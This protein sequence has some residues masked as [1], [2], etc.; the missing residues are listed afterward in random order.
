MMTSTRL[1][2]ISALAACALMLGAG[3]ALANA[4]NGAVTNS[5]CQSVEPSVDPTCT[6]PSQSADPSESPHPSETVDPSTADATSTD[7]PVAAD[8]YAAAGVDPAAPPADP[9]VPLTGLDNAIQHVLDNCI[10]NPQAPGLANALAHLVANR[11]LHAA[12]NAEK[13]AA[14]ASREVAKAARIAEHDTVHGTV[15][16]NTG[17]HGNSGH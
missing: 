1:R 3:A 6:D 14:K 8:C 12:H 4:G 5:T 7:A 9:T 11:D 16:G 10:K 17:T 15:H 2:L 13:A